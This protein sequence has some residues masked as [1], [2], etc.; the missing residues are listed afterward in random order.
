MKGILEVIIDP[1]VSNLCITL[2]LLK[3]LYVRPV[4]MQTPHYLNVHP[5]VLLVLITHFLESQS[6]LHLNT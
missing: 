3:I 2:D 4:F 1:I 6:F 5:S